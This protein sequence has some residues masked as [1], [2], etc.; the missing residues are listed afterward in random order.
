MEEFVKDE[1]D[2]IEVF[3][4]QAILF[5]KKYN[6]EAK[7]FAR[8]HD[9]ARVASNDSHRIEDIALTYMNLPKELLNTKDGQSF[10]ESLRG[11][12]NLTK[13]EDFYDK[14]T[15]EQYEPLF[16]LI[17]WERRNYLENILGKKVKALFKRQEVL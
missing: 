7:E 14:I 9:L 4:A 15:H 6:K 2:A 11:I 10:V 16:G 13:K 17:Q 1:V 5:L 8:K 3:N 12:L